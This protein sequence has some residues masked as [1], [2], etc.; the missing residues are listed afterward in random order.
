MDRIDAKRIGRSRDVRRKLGIYYTPDELSEV[1]T[2][3]AIRSAGDTIL[4]PSFGGC[5]FLMAARHRLEAFGSSTPLDNLYGCD[6]DKNAFSH[7]RLLF[8]DTAETR[9][10]VRAD[11]LET[12]NSYWPVDQFDV[13]LG[14]PPFVSH[15]NMTA[16]QKQTAKGALINNGITLPGTSSLWAYFAIHAT[17]FLKEG[18][19]LALILPD[20]FLTSHYAKPVRSHI[21]NHFESIVIARKCFRMFM[22]SGAS[23]R[24]LTLLADGYSR[25]KI[26][27][28][29]SV[30]PTFTISE[31]RAVVGLKSSVNGQSFSVDAVVREKWRDVSSRAFRRILREKQIFKVEDVLN[32]EIGLVTG[33]NKFFIIDEDTAKSWRLPRSN[34]FP[35]LSRTADAPGLVYSELDHKAAAKANRRCWLFRPKKLGLRHGA[36]RRYLA[37]VPR[38]LR[39]TTVWFKKRKFWFS[40]EGYGAP[41]G[42]VTYMNHY[43]PRII[44]NDGGVDCTNTLHRI[45]FKGH[46]GQSQKKLIAISLMTTFSQ[47]SAEL[48]GRTYGG[49][50]L[51]V[52]PSEFRRVSL[53]LPQGLHHRRVDKVFRVVDG[54]LRKGDP[55]AARKVADLL[56]LGAILD[57]NEL[58]SSMEELEKVLASLRSERRALAYS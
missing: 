11:F 22:G 41:H 1:V 3:W 5:G 27:S 44:L 7:L 48:E 9:Y 54:Y 21:F 23:E 12:D 53:I 36:V 16:D 29:V 56:I 52:E 43:G 47:I 6:I 51:K 30:T 24:T 38:K 39:R 35:I 50:V 49:G 32:V 8:G 33:A 55:N 10:F 31:L 34:L 13:V 20:A 14:N 4:E 26:S 2:E 46:T 19:R 17:L 15:H 45:N 58:T 42:F 40:P 18:G 28:H 25:K 57:A 37:S